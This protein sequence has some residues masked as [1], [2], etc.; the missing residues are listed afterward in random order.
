MTKNQANLTPIPFEPS[1]IEGSIITRFQR[2]AR[3]VPGQVAVDTLTEHLTYAQLDTYSDQIANA[4]TLHKGAVEKNPVALMIDQGH[5]AI[6]AILGILK[7]GRCVVALPTDSPTEQLHH[8]W[9]NTYKPLVLTTRQNLELTQAVIAPGNNWINIEDL[10]PDGMKSVEGSVKESQEDDLAMISYTSGSTG[11]PKGV[12]QSHRLIL[13]SAYQ[14]QTSYRLTPHDRSAVLAS[15]GYGAAKTQC[16]ATLLSGATLFLPDQKHANISTLIDWLQ[17]EKITVLAMP[18][19][20]MFRQIMDGMVAGIRLPSIR[21]VLLGGDDLYQQDVDRF[22]TFFGADTSLVFRLA[23]S[24]MN[25]LREIHIHPGMKFQAD[26]IPV[27]YPVPGKEVHLLDED[28]NEVPP[29]GIGEIVVRSRYLAEGYW[30]QPGLTSERFKPDPEGGDKRIFH[31]G[32]LARINTAG[33]MEHLGRKD[34]MVKIHGFSVHLE[35]VDQALMKLAYVKEAASSSDPLPGGDRRLVAYLVANHGQKPHVSEIRKE[36]AQYL[37]EH[38]HPSV[39]V[40]MEKLPRTSTGKVDRK[41]LPPPPRT[42]PDL[43][44]ALVQPRG[45]NEAALARVW[46]SLLQL[47][48]VGVEDNFFDLGGDSLLSV[49]MVIEAEKLFKT[50]VP[51]SYFQEPTIAHLVVQLQKEDEGTII[52]PGLS[53]QEGSHFKPAKRVTKYQAA[54]RK[55]L[56]R[57][58]TLNDIVRRMQWFSSSMSLVAK[59]QLIRRAVVTKPYNQGIVSLSVWASNPMVAHG[60]YR[61]Q[62]R[63]FK[64]FLGEIDGYQED[65]ELGFRNSL[66]GNVFSRLGLRAYS[67]EESHKL[68]KKLQVTTDPFWISVRRMIEEASEEEYVQCFPVSHFEYLEQ[69]YT[70]GRGVILLTYHNPINRLAIAALLRRLKGESIP[71]ISEKRARRE[72]QHWSNNMARDLPARELGALKAGIA[73]EG[74]QLLGQGKIVQF[75]SDN[76]YAR[77]GHAVVI[78]SRRYYLRPGFAELAINTGAA[79]VPQFSVLRPD[80]KIHM[81][82]HPPFVIE[83][84]SREE[85]ITSLLE[86]YAAFVNNS[87]RVAPESIRWPRIVRHFDQPIAHLHQP[88]EQR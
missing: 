67:E 77:E 45:E 39:F 81:T 59:D 54:I 15:F 16:F 55:I 27:G 34:N 71:T 33:Q 75:V 32:D 80:G 14:N 2:V 41:A 74:Q 21:L 11:I 82:I 48:E 26:K 19:I 63:L 44:N 35:S 49:Q 42:R 86:Q 72:S 64:R 37:P 24:E 3:S 52:P 66:M 65:P 68:T 31:T 6:A 7:A 36:I 47:D 60:L 25:L 46:M 8:L 28:G 70:A 22:F 58:M 87:W 57:R 83:Q 84:V 30:R 43:T 23:G 51:P 78:A 20:G 53:S 38:M 9:E 5:L 88:E 18:P 62:Y 17:S 79:V 1:E 10:D 56:K 73:L 69:A 4:V 76:E 61:E 12:M 13:Q 50:K 85:Q 29:G 40:W